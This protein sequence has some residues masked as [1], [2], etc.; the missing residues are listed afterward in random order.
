MKTTKQAPKGGG[1]GGRRGDKPK[2][3]DDKD[4]LHGIGE[5]SDIMSLS[6]NIVYKA[7][8]VLLILAAAGGLVMTA[9]LKGGKH[10]DAE[11]LNGLTY[12]T[13]CENGKFS[14]ECKHSAAMNFHSSLCCGKNRPN[15]RFRVSNATG[16]HGDS[17][18]ENAETANAF[19]ES[20]KNDKVSISKIF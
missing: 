11:D 14:I 5:M 16:R 13:V 15:Q 10:S 3:R 2:D 19:L 6:P 9:G 12:A 4:E 20:L 1:G 17:V 18:G 7:L 8:I